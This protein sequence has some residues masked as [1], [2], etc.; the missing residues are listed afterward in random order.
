MKMLS[1][2]LHILVMLYLSVSVGA[3]EPAT[4]VQ[5][6]NNNIYFYGAVSESSTL[7]LKTKLE[8]LD[9]HLQTIAIHY[10]IEAPPIHLHI[11]SYGGSL[12]HTYYIMDV[13]KLLK[14]PVYT[15]IDGF[16]ASAATLMSVCGKRRFMTESSVMLVHQLSSSASGK[17][18]EIKN[19][20]SNLVEFMEIIK[21]TYLNYG[22]ISSEHLD[23][24]L[25]QDLWLNS[26][27]SL[28]YGFV[29]EIIKSTPPTK[30][31]AST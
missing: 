9:L 12:L 10:K 25:K 16:A 17:F 20:Y 3:A 21:K 18:E 7:Q 22:N 15:Y 29:D 13:I 4:T 28:E 8:E 2:S 26:A 23:A 24:L 19:E 5:S 31:E 1:S 27:K 6:T 14:T 30:A 11:Q